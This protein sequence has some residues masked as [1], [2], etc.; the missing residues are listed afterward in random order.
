MA[1]RPDGGGDFVYNCTGVLIAPTV[2]LTAAH[3]LSFN[4]EL[5]RDTAVSFMAERPTEDSFVDAE[6]I[7]PH[8]DYD[9]FG[10]FTNLDLGIIILKEDVAMQEYAQLHLWDILT[11]SMMIRTQ[12]K[13]TLQLWATVF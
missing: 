11:P 8:P 1:T 3:C 7:I 13:K 6:E 10:S 2:L 4:G 9:E 5:V 12:A